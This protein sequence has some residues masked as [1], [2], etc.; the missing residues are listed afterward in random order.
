MDRFAA[1]KGIVQTYRETGSVR[2]VT[3][4]WHTSRQVIRTWVHRFEKEGEAD[5]TTALVV[6][7]AVRTRPLKRRNSRSPGSGKRQAI[8]GNAR[9]SIWISRRQ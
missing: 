6:D 8:G 2:K 1:R 3:S 9:P 5:C 7:I 4:I